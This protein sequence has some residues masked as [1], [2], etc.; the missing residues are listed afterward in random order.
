[1]LKGVSA[2][3]EVAGQRMLVADSGEDPVVEMRLLR[4]L[5][6]WSSGVILCSPRMPAAQLTEVTSKVNRLVTINRPIIGCPAVILDFTTGIRDICAHLRELGH[7]HL[8]YLQGPPLAWSD[9]ERRRALRAEARRGLRV[10]ILPCGARMTA[11]HAATDAA[12]ASGATAIVA[13]SD[14]VALGVLIRADELR[15]RVPEDMSVTGFDDIRS[16]AL[17]AQV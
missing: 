13:F 12:L 3:A 10:D 4:E 6:R 5:T 16:A 2:A 9:A 14:Y 8:V 7:E 17:L 15:L 1:M 11:G